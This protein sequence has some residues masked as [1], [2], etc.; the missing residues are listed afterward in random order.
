MLIL[1]HDHY[2]HLDY[3]TLPLLLPKIR[4]VYTAIGVG[5]HLEYWGFPKEMITEFDWWDSKEI[6]EGVRL[7]AAPAR[8]FSGRTFKRSQALWCSFILKIAN[9]NFYI[10]AD[11]GYDTHF[12]DIGKRFGPFDIAFLETG[13]YN[14]DWPLIHMMPEE[15][16]QAAVDLR[17]RWMLPVHWGKFALAFH[18]WS[19][20]AERVRKKAAALGVSVTTP[21]IGEPV[22]LNESYPNA[23]WWK[24][25]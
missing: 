18:P 22:V 9:Y 5:A 15:A 21:R 10:G 8:H 11:S 20:P 7:T 14:E 4:S 23:E 25:V 19:E 12:T 16:V 17:A 1:T 13:Q 24:D 3:D 6:S 2:D